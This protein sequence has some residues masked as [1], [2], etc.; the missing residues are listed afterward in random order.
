[1]PGPGRYGNKRRPKRPMVGDV[2]GGAHLL[3]A[4][5][6]PWAIGG[7]PSRRSA[8]A[9]RDQLI[10]KLAAKAV[11][12]KQIRPNIPGDGKVQM[13]GGPGTGTFPVNIPGKP[14]PTF[15]LPSR[16]PGNRFPKR[17][18]APGN[19]KPAAGGRGMYR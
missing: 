6:G 14:R 8:S 4:K 13:R 12:G 10:K 5:G 9:S 18:L 11:G 15:T 7:K 16:K 3:P 1:M 2:Y 17:P 19:R